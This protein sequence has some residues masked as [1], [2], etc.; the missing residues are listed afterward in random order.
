MAALPE[1]AGAAGSRESRAAHVPPAGRAGPRPRSAADWVRLIRTLLPP[2]IA[3]VVVVFQ[4]STAALLT[5][6]LQAW[7]QLA[8][9]GLVGPA[10]T[11]FTLT[12]ILG[13][14]RER[15]RVAEEL[16][17]ANS[18][19]GAS[20]RRNQALRELASRLAEAPDLNAVASAA[21]E[22]VR[23]AL[24]AVAAALVLGPDRVAARSLGLD[25]S[26]L[27]EALRVAER[28]RDRRVSERLPTAIAGAESHLAIPLVWA[29][30]MVGSLHLFLRGAVG[31]DDLALAQTFAAEIAGASEA[32]RTRDRDLVTIYE[33][34]RSIRAER[35]LERLLELVLEQMAGRMGAARGGVYLVDEGD[36]LICRG[37]HGLLPVAPAP[38]S[39]ERGFAARVA[40]S[41]QAMLETRDQGSADP[42]AIAA[43]ARSVVGFPMLADNE[44]IGVIVLADER[45]A[46]FDPRELPLMSLLASQATL[47]VRNA[48]AYLYSEELAINEERNRIARDIHD[49]L[50][51]SLAFASLKL[52][53][54]AR[55]LETDPG[56]SRPELETVRRTLRENI[57]ELRRSIFALRPIDL[58]RLGFVATLRKY[59]AEFSEQHGLRVEV[60]APDSFRVGQTTE[61]TLFRI[62]QEAMNNIAKHAGAS[63]ATVSI[64][65]EDG[66]VLLSVHDDGRGFESASAGA[67]D[68]PSLAGGIGIRAIQERVAARGGTFE[69]RSR[70]GQGTHL[71][72]RLPV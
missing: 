11:W 13:Q 59:A 45:A 16:R 26:G 32:A 66:S 72:V 14:V 30:H 41:R 21:L 68:P 20:N 17:A 34:D 22:Q 25:E 43:G 47:A 6:S 50:A 70:P 24:P 52:D 10:V 28:V 71:D 1:A 55:L 57:K 54:A 51:Q 9:Y 33:V 64:A 19:L 67:E 62:V 8:F 35:N 37:T 65:V 27:E 69:I 5:N 39:A 60:E 29:E 58:E 46:A 48:R 4:F 38:L 63:T 3:V 49:G 61:G 42:D 36:L 31:G 18:A 53:L 7:A 2:A 12:W 44:L 23:I 56:R 15:E 40:R